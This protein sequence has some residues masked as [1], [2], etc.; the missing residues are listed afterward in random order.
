MNV[1][2][3]EVVL[4][5]FEFNG[6]PGN[7]QNV[8]C[9]C[10]RELR[11]GRSGRLWHDQLGSA[12]PYRIDNRTLF[13]AF[14]ASAELQ[15]HLAL[16]W[17][18]PENVLDLFAE[19]RCMRNHS[20]DNQD[21][22]GLLDALDRFKISN[23]GIVAKQHWRDVVMR[24]NVEEIER[25]REGI[26]DYCW[27][28][29]DALDQLLPHMPVTNWGEALL[30][31]SYMK[32]DAWM[33][34]RG[35][36]VDKPLR[37][38]LATHWEELRGAM[39]DDLNTRYPVFEKRVFKQ[40]LLARWMEKNE[41]C[42]WPRTPSGLY[43]TEKEVLRAMSERCPAAEE[44]CS[45]KITLNQLKTFD[46]AVGDDWRNRCMLSAFRTKT[47]R[48]A[49]SNSEFVFGLNA[50]FRSLIKPGPDSALV[51]LDFGGQ[52]FAIAAY[53]SGD[54]NMISAYES[55]DPYSEWARRTGAMPTEGNHPQIR[56]VY[57]RAALGV[58]FGMGAQTM[59]EYVGVPVARA[60]QLLKSHREFFPRFWQWSEA[61]HDA[62][63]QTRELFTVFGWRMR[64]RRD[65]NERTLLNYPMQANGA[66]MLRL[67]CIYA[68]QRN[69]PIIAPV[70]D[71]ILIEAPRGSVADVT[72]AM[73]K[74][75][76]DASR[77]VLGGP[78][79]RVDI[80]PPL[81]YPDRYVDGRGEALWANTLRL[82]DQL[83]RKVA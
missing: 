11:S 18:L 45:T 82:L 20:G 19:Y 73:I 76:Q 55:G 24:E 80:K 26:L 71:A 21:A 59:A 62:G 68:V 61:V 64:V 69:V 22:A 81:F 8:I 48:N 66:E 29:I 47:G 65:V 67:A 53:L 38:D 16:G 17:P 72:R 23:I 9:L 44:L 25:G 7:R 42:Y 74:C 50:A 60:R 31:G 36:P 43:S 57:K 28:D 46:L 37:D 52:E 14:Y 30:R 33:V 56:A 34:H 51:Y 39:I 2:F 58:I 49:P 63:I 77:V 5:D 54:K 15:C 41:I 78:V 13:V 70:H 6:Q 35:I 40:E 4:A 3:D 79:V 32:A 27:T 75:M 12:P 10:W 1:P 83:K